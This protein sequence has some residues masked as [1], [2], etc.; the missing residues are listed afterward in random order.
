MSDIGRI[1]NVSDIKVN[2]DSRALLCSNQAMPF[3]TDHPDANVIAWYCVAQSS[4]GGASLLVDS[5]E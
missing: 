4:N 3:H 2:P 1:T 5:R